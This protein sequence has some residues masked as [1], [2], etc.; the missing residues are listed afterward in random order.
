MTHTF[1]IWHIVTEPS[2]TLILYETNHT[3]MSVCSFVTTICQC[4]FKSI[5]PH[6][7]SNWVRDIAMSWRGRFAFGR[8]E[9]LVEGCAYFRH[10]KAFRFLISYSVLHQRRQYYFSGLLPASR[11]L[12]IPLP[13]PQ[14]FLLSQL[15]CTVQSRLRVIHIPTNRCL[16]YIKYIRNK[17]I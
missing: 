6:I 12:Y 8:I 17:N 15:F 14:I 3:N 13:T 7:F 2:F 10:T 9:D 1:C 5:W 16:L 11:F 4:N